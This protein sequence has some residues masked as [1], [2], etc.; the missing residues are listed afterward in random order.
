VVRGPRIAGPT[1]S[2]IAQIDNTAIYS[3]QAT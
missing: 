1:A 2:T 3:L